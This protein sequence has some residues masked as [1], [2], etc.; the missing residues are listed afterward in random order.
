MRRPNSK[1]HGLNSPIHRGS[2]TRRLST[3]IIPYSKAI[4]LILLFSFALSFI[5]S[6][7]KLRPV[8]RDPFCEYISND[9]QKDD[10]T[11]HCKIVIDRIQYNVTD[12]TEIHNLPRFANG[13]RFFICTGDYANRF[14]RKINCP[15]LNA[16]GS[17]IISLSS[18]SIPSFMTPCKICNRS[19]MSKKLSPPSRDPLNEPIK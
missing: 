6:A 7:K 16:C 10:S 4:I 9:S 14:H 17:E 15:G 1:R 11:L 19:S 12:S 8:P 3:R 18:D 13:K 2:S 5:A